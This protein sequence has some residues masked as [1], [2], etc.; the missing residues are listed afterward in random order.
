MREVITVTGKNWTQEEQKISL[1]IKE[2][3]NQISQ[4]NPSMVLTEAYLQAIVQLMEEEK[5][6]L[7]ILPN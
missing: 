2:R 7:L 1:L 5:I 3:Q 6:P 4:M